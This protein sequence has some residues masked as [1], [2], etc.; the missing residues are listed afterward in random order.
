MIT[1]S[2]NSEQL[3]IEENEHLDKVLNANGFDESMPF[4]V[5]VNG[6]FVPRTSYSELL[7]KHE[8]ALDVVSPVGGG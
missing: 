5:A 7:V 6:E 2:I 4:A 3:Q 8:D 1:I